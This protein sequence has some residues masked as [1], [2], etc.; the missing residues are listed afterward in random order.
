MV[1]DNVGDVAR[2]EGRVRERLPAAVREVLVH[3]PGFAEIVRTLDQ[4]RR[5]PERR[6]YD[7]QMGEVELGLEVQLDGHILPSVLRLPPRL[8]NGARFHFVDDLPDPMVL[9]RIVLR[10]AARIAQEAFLLLQMGHDA[11]ALRTHPAAGGRRL[12]PILT[13]YQQIARG[14]IAGALLAR[15]NTVEWC[16]IRISITG[17]LSLTR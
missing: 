11:V 5:R 4:H 10:F 15:M 1:A 2:N 16:P 17:S 12:E 6:E 3:V 9:H 8:L 14:R 7:D 13:P